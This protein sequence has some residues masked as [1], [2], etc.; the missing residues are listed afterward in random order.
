MGSD[1]DDDDGGEGVRER[2]ES[3]CFLD[4]LRLNILP[5]TIICVV[6]II[7]FLLNSFWFSST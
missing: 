7:I 3:C 1:G 6:V 2:L 5:M 4:S